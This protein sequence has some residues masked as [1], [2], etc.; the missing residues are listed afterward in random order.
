MHPRA[1]GRQ[2][3]VHGF[4]D[5]ALLRLKPLGK[6]RLG[7]G[8]LFGDLAQPAGQLRLAGA[9]AHRC[10]RQLGDLATHVRQRP[11]GV[12]GAADQN[13]DHRDQGNKHRC[14]ESD[15]ERDEQ[16]R[17]GPFDDRQIHAFAVPVSIR[18]TETVSLAS[19]HRDA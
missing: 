13:D 3:F 4:C 18:V 5:L 17:V 8:A 11:L 7:G 9:R 16:R 10:F 15:P 2:P 1:D 6:L 19:G 14:A 12:G